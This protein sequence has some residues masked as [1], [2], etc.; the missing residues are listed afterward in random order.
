MKKSKNKNEYTS[1]PMKKKETLKD[2]KNTQRRKKN[3]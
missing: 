2:S 3:P 1:V